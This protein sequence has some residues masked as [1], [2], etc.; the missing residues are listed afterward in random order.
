MNDQPIIECLNTYMDV[1]PPGFAS[2]CDGTGMERIFVTIHVRSYK[3]TVCLTYPGSSLCLYSYTFK[4]NILLHD[5]KTCRIALDLYPFSY[6]LRWSSLFPEG[7][8]I[9][10]RNERNHRPSYGGNLWCVWVIK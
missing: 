6:M 10:G 8:G 7:G 9:K 1:Y 2:F 3:C 5:T 4:M